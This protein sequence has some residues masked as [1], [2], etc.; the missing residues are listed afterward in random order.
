[1]YTLSPW[2]SFLALLVFRVVVSCTGAS[3]WSQPQGLPGADLSKQSL[4]G[5]LPP[6]GHV[7][8]LAQP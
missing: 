3:G 5:L 6:G 1:M 8:L 7:Y 2:W 4:C